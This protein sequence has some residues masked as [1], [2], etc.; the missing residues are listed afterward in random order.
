M[1]PSVPVL[2]DT[3]FCGRPVQKMCVT[4]LA[5][6]PEVDRPKARDLTVFG[7]RRIGI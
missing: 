3:E 6:E 1:K 7:L 4:I 5:A 2:A